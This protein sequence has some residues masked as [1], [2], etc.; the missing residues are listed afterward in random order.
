MVETKRY[1][2]QEIH[3][4]DGRKTVFFLLDIRIIHVIIY[5]KDI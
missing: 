5:L 3:E 1:T 4:L 2:R